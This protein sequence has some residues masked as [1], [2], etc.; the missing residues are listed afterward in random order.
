[1]ILYDRSTNWPAVLDERHCKK[2]CYYTK[3]KWYHICKGK[4]PNSSLKRRKL[5]LQH[6]WMGSFVSHTFTGWKYLVDAKRSFQP[7]YV[8]D[9]VWMHSTFNYSRWVKAAQAH[10]MFFLSAKNRKLGL[11]S[12]QSGSPYYPIGGKCE[13]MFHFNLCFSH[14]RA[15]YLL[16]SQHWFPSS[17]DQ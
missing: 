13:H 2:S 8:E 9:H 16:M 7:S 17:A 10:Q 5:D 12:N 3:N 6:I 1:M 11:Q 14:V 15:Y 4:V